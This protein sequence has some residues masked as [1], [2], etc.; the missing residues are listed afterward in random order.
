MWSLDRVKAAVPI[1]HLVP[2]ELNQESVWNGE[3]RYLCP[4][5]ADTSPSLYVNERTQKWGCN[6]CF[7]HSDVIEFVQMLHRLKWT[8]ARDY[9][10]ALGRDSRWRRIRQL[11]KKTF[12]VPVSPSDQKRTQHR[13]VRGVSTRWRDM[14]AQ[15]RDSTALAALTKP[16]YV[17]RFWRRELTQQEQEARLAYMWARECADSNLI[18]REQC[19][20]VVRLIDDGFIADFSVHK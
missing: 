20:I 16:R 11:M 6:V 9:I 3:P 7:I 14:T 17:D 1:E 19:R 2:F 4:F 15:E 13:P 10:E 5:H 8:Q 12:P 18:T